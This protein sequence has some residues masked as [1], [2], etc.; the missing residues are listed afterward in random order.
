[1]ALAVAAGIAVS[2]T[3]EGTLQW[4]DAFS[5][6]STD[7]RPLEAGPGSATA[8]G[9]VA[10][11]SAE[12]ISHYHNASSKGP[13]DT[14]PLDADSDPGLATGGHND[15]IFV[16]AECGCSR[17][18]HPYI[19]SSN[20]NTDTFILEFVETSIRDRSTSTAAAT[21]ATASSAAAPT[22]T[23]GNFTPINY[24]SFTPIAPASVSATAA[25]TAPATAPGPVFRSRMA[26][27]D[28]EALA[29]ADGKR[30]C[31]RCR[32]ARGLECFVRSS[33]PFGPINGDHKMCNKCRL[34]TI[35]P[36]RRPSLDEFG[37]QYLG[38]KQED[39]DE[40][41]EDEEDD[42]ED[43]DEEEEEEEDEEDDEEVVADDGSETSLE[44]YIAEDYIA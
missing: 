27:A 35:K 21:A 19:P 31:N 24:T 4:R 17:A 8:A 26:K 32:V 23:S 10:S 44:D 34:S 29:E 6:K 33:V 22:I 5:N 37:R 15:G 43:D 12:G 13:T 42:K 2:G 11:D 28:A 9:N 1:M 18:L 40:E 30:R 38:E 16:C 39:E 7:T 20:N 25:A 3:V 36:D 14:T 41:D